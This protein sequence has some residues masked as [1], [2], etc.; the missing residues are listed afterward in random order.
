LAGGLD[1]LY[2]HKSLAPLQS[3]VKVKY[4][5]AFL[6][7][8][9]ILFVK[10]KKTSYEVKHYLPLEMFEM[11]DVTEGAFEPESYRITC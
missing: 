7:R 10:V 2:H 5:G 3:P 9:F 11:I 8:G 6:Y 1:V 4:M